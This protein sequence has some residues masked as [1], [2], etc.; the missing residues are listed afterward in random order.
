M[1]NSPKPPP[2][3]LLFA[4]CLLIPLGPAAAQYN[5]RQQ[6]GMTTTDDPRR[7]PIPARD[8]SADPVLVLRG[9]TLID[10]TGAAPIADAVV[11]L[12]GNRVVAAGPAATTSLP[13]RVDRTVEVAG[14]Y[15][16]PGLIDLHMH[17]TQQRGDDFTRY[18]DSDAA[19]AIR[20]V[21]KLGWFLDGG[22]TAV[23]DVGT[24][25]DVAVRLKEAVQR[26]IVAGPRVFWSGKSIGIRSGH[27]DE[28]TATASGL[29]TS[30]AGRPES[31]R[32]ANGASDWRLAVREQI[33]MGADW[34]KLTAPYTREEVA[35]AIDEAHMHGIRVTA[36]AFGDY[37]TWAVEAGIDNI[38]H[39]LSIPDETLPLMAEKGTA[40]VPTLTAFYN[41]LTY[42]Y[43]SA[44]IPPGGFHYT[45]SR[46]FY[47]SHDM[48]IET[49][50]KARAAGV[51]VGIGT[52]IPFEGEKRHP[53]DYFTEL[54][55]FKDAGYTN[56]EIL[57]A[58]TRMGAD[59]LGM[60]DRLGTLEPGRLA[61]VLVVAG[62]PLEDIQHLRNMRLVV[63]DGRIVRDRLSAGP[64]EETA[65]AR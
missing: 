43:P 1:R 22:I 29:P 37:V 59:I 65:A 60:G 45:M 44:G 54:G 48:H 18:H 40:L 19:A 35:A 46:R 28:I 31:K 57:A 62:N 16:V 39:P 52:D 38:E 17:F 14:L 42:G 12:R 23:R 11:V 30:L 6:P 33:R 56:E 51:K 5:L 15:L 10:G 24:R 34:I 13:S 21:E 47:M 4:I 7:I 20:G 49:M 53:H 36:D 8:T 25:N 2:A 41:P 26:G 55:F 63:A 9:G 61:D 32:V 27:G 58:A 64:T 3:S 50:R